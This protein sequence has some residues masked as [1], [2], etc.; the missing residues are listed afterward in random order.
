[1]EGQRKYDVAQ[2][3]NKLMRRAT[4]EKINE[5]GKYLGRDEVGSRR[6]GE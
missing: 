4:D 1:M 6:R 3:M 2:G 5:D